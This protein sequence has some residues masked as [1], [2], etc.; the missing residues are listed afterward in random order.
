MNLWRRFRKL[1]GELNQQQATDP[2]LEGRVYRSELRGRIS[3][4]LSSLSPR[5][6]EILHLVFYQELTVEEAASVLGVSVGSARTH[7]H[8]GKEK[9]RQELRKRGLEHDTAR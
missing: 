4:I 9:I 7:Y 2:G 8:R 1:G 5:Q 3:E 6:R